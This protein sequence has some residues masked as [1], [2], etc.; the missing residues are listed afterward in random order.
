MRCLQDVVQNS[1]NPW[2]AIQPGSIGRRLFQSGPA[3]GPGGIPDNGPQGVN[4]NITNPDQNLV[5]L[6]R[7]SALLERE[8]RSFCLM[9]SKKEAFTLAQ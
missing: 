9:L 4:V 1:T 2:N 6:G 7:A 3:P 5:A 8:K